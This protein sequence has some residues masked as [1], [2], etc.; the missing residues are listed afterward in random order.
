MCQGREETEP[1]NHPAL[2]VCSSASVHGDA[3]EPV[4]ASPSRTDVVAV[5]KRLVRAQSAEH[6]L[7]LSS[8]SGS[9]L[10]ARVQQ[11]AT[12]LEQLDPNPSP[13][14]VE[15]LQRMLARLE[16]LE[17]RVVQMLTELVP[18]DELAFGRLLALYELISSTV[19]LY[20]SALSATAG[21]KPSACDRPTEPSPTG[22]WGSA[23]LDSPSLSEP[24]SWASA[25]R[26]RGEDATAHNR[27]AL[28]SS[29]PGAA[30]GSVSGAELTSAAGRAIGSARSRSRRV[31]LIALAQP[32]ANFRSRS[33]SSPT[34]AAELSY[35]ALVCDWS[36]RHVSSSETLCSPRAAGGAVG[37]QP[38][39]GVCTVQY[40]EAAEHNPP[41][42]FAAVD[43]R[44][45]PSNPEGLRKS[46]REHVNQQCERLAPKAQQKVDGADRPSAQRRP[47]EDGKRR[48][49]HQQRSTR[50]HRSGK[51]D[52][53]RSSEHQEAPEP[54][55]AST[56]KREPRER[57]RTRTRKHK[58]G[59]RSRRHHKHSSRS[60]RDHRERR[61]KRVASAEA[62][63][64]AKLGDS[65]LLS[66]LPGATHDPA[67]RAPSSR[68]T[69]MPSSSSSPLPSLSLKPVESGAVEQSSSARSVHEMRLASRE[70]GICWEECDPLHS[71]GCGHSYCEECL[72]GYLENRVQEGNVLEIPCP[73]PACDGELLPHVIGALLSEERY[74]KYQRFT[75]LAALSQDPACRWCPNKECGNAL[76]GDP[77][78]P[79][80]RC[81]ECSTDFCYRCQQHWHP[82]LTCEEF[83]NKN[84]RGGE[85]QKFSRW[86]RRN[87]AKPCPR[88]GVTIQKNKGCNHII[89]DACKYEFCWL[90]LEYCEPG[91]FQQ[92]AC[93]GRQFGRLDRIK[94]T[95]AMVG[96][97]TLWGVAFV[98][99]GLVVLAL[100]LPVALVALPVIG[101]NR[102]NRR[103]HQRARLKRVR[104]TQ[105]AAEVDPF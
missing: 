91:H 89:C 56:V 85:E 8:P 88:C 34:T 67:L 82:N 57:M 4:S 16:Q 14:E 2:L 30:S 95:A 83:S 65:R 63:A 70:C 10:A 51:A 39:E 86:K 50:K 100:A 7:S 105:R 13:E 96:F 24:R 102:I 62:E 103:R 58:H 71:L 18:A 81:P 99:G 92:G 1:D 23:L 9:L 19:D 60:R 87:K 26:H 38:S 97:Y 69:A 40:A 46:T 32:L 21:V 77:S 76:I 27:N 42:V 29:P 72:V 78:Q 68:R 35:C 45:R 31:P 94:F 48:S 98:G 75:L 74:E 41:V 44:E 84:Q 101:V 64:L 6:P 36:P 25:P 59:E 33:Q 66:S 20:P 15:Y 11:F 90:C 3:V 79:Q 37:A 61:E 55:S 17:Q 49:T 12:R 93:R 22:S 5:T 28:G 54:I 52:E 53:V 73:D 47:R 80:M 104:R 43:K